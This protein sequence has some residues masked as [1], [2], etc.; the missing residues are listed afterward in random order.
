MRA[1]LLH[2]SAIALIV[3]LLPAAI[4]VAPGHGQPAETAPAAEASGA[5]ALS[6]TAVRSFS[7]PEN[8]RVVFEFSRAAVF[9]SADSGETRDLVISLPGE[10]T[11]RAAGVDPVFRVRDGVVDSVE[12]DTG[13]DGASFRLRFR[14][15][16]RFRV[17][18][19]EAREDQP[20]RLVVQVARAGGEQAV[21]RRLE[22]IAQGKR[23]DRVRVVAV[24][25]GHGGP[26]AGA[27]GP[28]KLRVVEKTVTLAVARALVEELN[29]M[30]GVRGELTRDGD[31]FIPLRDRYQMAEKMKADLFI[32][33]HANSTR[34]RGSGRGTEV[35]FLS[36]R[37][38][39]DQA[40]ADLADLENA[41]D[42]VGGVP[43]E[44]ENDLVSILYDVKRTSALEQSQLLAETLLDHVA[45]DRRL[46]SRGVKQAGFVVLKSV[47]FPSVLVET[48]FINNPVEARLLMSREFQQRMARQLAAG[49][50]RYFER[51]RAELRGTNGPGSN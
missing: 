15:T 19:V 43:P 28:R 5:G 33:V 42:L 16:A 11:A 22:G 30:P 37:G 1:S 39:S 7:G 34:R 2:R 25:A 45:S 50:R 26:D 36:L 44:A 4:G 38:A 51:T 46:E 23:R 3:G 27:R 14:S 13:V 35:F 21:E 49:V 29:Q 17:A 8:T 18:T 24:D 20:F 41:A 48:A 31:Y 40:D 9:V 12:I 10:A 6:L 32:S 47:E